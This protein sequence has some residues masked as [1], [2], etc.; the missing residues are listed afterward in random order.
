MVSGSDESE[1][2]VLQRPRRERGSETRNFL[3]MFLL[4][5]VY[6]GIVFTLKQTHPKLYEIF[7][8]ANLTLYDLEL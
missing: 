7:D 3:V 5:I 1:F 2:S 6:K 8:E 4:V